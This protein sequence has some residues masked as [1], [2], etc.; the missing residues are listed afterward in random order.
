MG[1][2]EQSSHS[3]TPSSSRRI[4]LPSCWTA[5][6]TERRRL[7]SSD[8]DGAGTRGRAGAHERNRP[9][10][11]QTAANAIASSPRG[12]HR[13]PP[14][15]HSLLSAAFPASLPLSARLQ[16]LGDALVVAHVALQSGPKN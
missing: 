3:P 15:L 11:A 4:L 7:A 13:P 6:R 5:L 1:S 16:G 2:E 8:R 10:L 9:P 12:R 14:V